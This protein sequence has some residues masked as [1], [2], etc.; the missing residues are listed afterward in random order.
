MIVRNTRAI[1]EHLARTG[2]LL[3]LSNSDKH[4]RDSILNYYRSRDIVEK[5]FDVEKNQLDGKR[6]RGHTPYN[7]D[8]RIFVKFVAL[9]LHSYLSKTMKKTKLLEQYSVR[10]MLAE[11]SK[12]RCTMLHEK[13]LISE[14]SKSQRNIFKAF[15]IAP[16]MVTQS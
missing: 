1:S 8:G 5:M 11:I 13:M 9:I 10:E 14:I 16:E 4:D 2:Y 15:E 7:A 3:F 12:I 6:L